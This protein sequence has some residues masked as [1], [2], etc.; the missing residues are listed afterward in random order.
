MNLLVVEDLS[1][2]LSGQEVL[3]SVSLALGP[4]E[5]VGLVGANGAGKSSLLHVIAGSRPDFLGEVTVGG[6]RP[7]GPAAQR[8]TGFVPSTPPLYDYLTVQEHLDLLAALWRCPEGLVGHTVDRYRLE[9]LLGRLAGHLSLGQRQ[10]VAL[11][12]VSFH[13][14][15]LLLLDEPFNGLD[16]ETA[17]FIRDELARHASSGGAAVIATHGIADVAPIVTRLMVLHEG[18]LM[19]D[20]EVDGAIFAD[21]V[22]KAWKEYSIFL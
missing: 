8:S 22:K 18:R 10:R 12:L 14:P 13:S 17:R 5:V 1:L 7:G 4:G 21:E 6:G 19:R 3:S 16:E 15:G 20:R 9:G 11:S 2:R